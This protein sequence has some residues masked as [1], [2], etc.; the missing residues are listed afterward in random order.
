MPI[1]TPPV[2]GRRG[3]QYKAQILTDKIVALKAELAVHQEKCRHPERHRTYK[4]RSNTGNYDPTQDFY[5]T[6][7]HCE[8]CLRQWTTNDQRNVVG[9]KM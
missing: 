1:Y 4:Y 5:W 6:E 3:R 2:P 9:R 7:Y 8:L